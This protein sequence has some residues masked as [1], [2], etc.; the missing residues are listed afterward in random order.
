MKALIIV[1]VQN[2]F[3]KGGALEVKNADEVVKV[4]NSISDKFDKVIATQDWHPANH[5]SFA[6]NNKNVKPLDMIELNGVMQIMW[7]DHC[8]QGSKGAEFHPN[9]NTNV[10]DLIVRKGTNPNI[11]SYSAFLEN[12]HKTKTGLEFYLKGLGIKKLYFAGLATDYCVYFSI[13]DAIEA[14]FETNL[15]LDAC[16]GVDFPDNNVE[17][18]VNLMKVSGVNIIDSGNL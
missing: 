1:D 15:I 10:I 5:R 7:P 18:C 3:C 4:I 2:D 13:M 17:R 11:D 12:D 14:G 16:R 9:L 8:V 6:S